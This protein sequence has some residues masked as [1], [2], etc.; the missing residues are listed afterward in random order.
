[1]DRDLTKLALEPWRTWAP[2][3]L[4]RVAR[5]TAAAQWHRSATKSSCGPYITSTASEVA[6]PDEQLRAA[7]RTAVEIASSRE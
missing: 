7:L 1:L 3:R 5:A 6:T 4:Q 2:E